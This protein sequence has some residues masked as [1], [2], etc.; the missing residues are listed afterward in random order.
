[1]VFISYVVMFLILSFF[2]TINMFKKF[3]GK[4]FL[5]RCKFI[6]YGIDLDKEAK[7]HEQQMASEARKMQ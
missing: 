4:G 2:D 6:F 7:R 1:M 5:A 3:D